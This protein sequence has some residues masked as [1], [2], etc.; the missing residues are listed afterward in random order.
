MA[1]WLWPLLSQDQGLADALGVPLAA[2][3]DRVWPDVAP[4]G[5]QAPWIVYSVQE[6]LDMDALGGGPRLGA[7]IPVNVRVVTQGQ[8]P[9]AASAAVRRLYALLH[10]NHNH[11]LPAGGVILTGRRTASLAYPE[12]AG[13]IQYRHTGGLYEVLVN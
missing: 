2:L 13:G 9:G 3:P 1:E 7:A 12:D 4:G 6:G 11:P 5:T 10:G 8:D